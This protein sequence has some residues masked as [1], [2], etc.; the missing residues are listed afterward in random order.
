M[1]IWIL[2]VALVVLGLAMIL[3]PTVAAGNGQ[4]SSDCDGVC[5]CEGSGNQN[6]PGSGA[7]NIAR[8]SQRAN[9]VNSGD[10]ECDGSQRRTG[11]VL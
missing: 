4:G 9:C 8:G 2:P 11:S 10:G 3:A 5:D 1:K 6:G 7:G